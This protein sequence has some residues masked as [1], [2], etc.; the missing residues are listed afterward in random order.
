M[1]KFEVSKRTIK[2]L[3]LLFHIILMGGLIW[4]VTQ[5]SIN[6]FKYNV[7]S[8]IE[9][10]LPG[11]EKP[12]AMNI[13]FDAYMVRNRT[14]YS[15]FFDTFDWNRM[16]RNMTTNDKYRG[17]KEYV[18]IESLTRN[19][20]LDLTLEA[21][22]LF[23]D[24][25]MDNGHIVSRLKYGIRFQICYQLVNA[26]DTKESYKDRYFQ[27][28]RIQDREGIANTPHVSKYTTI[29]IKE[30]Y[31][32]RVLS[33]TEPGFLPKHRSLFGESSW[34][35]FSY[36][37]SY[38]YDITKLGSP[39]TDHC[40]QYSK[41][42]FRDRNDAVDSCVD[43]SCFDTHGK[44]SATRIYFT[45][46]D[47]RYSMSPDLDVIDHCNQLYQSDDCHQQT[48]IPSFH[49][50]VA[51]RS[52]HITIHRSYSD[53]SSY[54]ITSQDKIDDIDYVTYVF[55][56][57]GTW[58][59]FSFLLINPVI[60]FCVEI[61]SSDQGSDSDQSTAISK[62]EYANLMTRITQL[63]NPVVTQMETINQSIVHLSDVSSKQ[64]DEIKHFQARIADVTQ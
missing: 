62:E 17:G 44:G 43:E 1:N 25:H 39:Y 3:N 32:G 22:E 4:Q 7:V 55:G 27:V 61:L 26:N 60:L 45:G 38:A 31:A 21:D 54:F 9:I 8:S 58:F 30:D 29:D 40:V 42:G 20:L 57:M 36:I 64:G 11:R 13:C 15:S 6:Y 28:S 24:D 59:G 46:N 51:I 49:R 35:Y 23:P 16:T 18:A 41:I 12:K 2:I 50:N 56:A 19:E 37:S 14:K 34:A 33:L 10:I 52:S 63:T 5:I 48:H 47:N 53:E